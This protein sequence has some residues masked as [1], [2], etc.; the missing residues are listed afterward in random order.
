MKTTFNAFPDN[1]AGGMN[2]VDDVVAMLGVEVLAVGRR[3]VVV[4]QFFNFFAMY[5]IIYGLICKQFCQRFKNASFV[6]N[7]GSKNYKA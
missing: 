7:F 1:L 4:L 3:A 2:A 6:Q 5:V